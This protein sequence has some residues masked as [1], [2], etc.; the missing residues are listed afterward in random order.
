MQST[1]AGVRYEG[2]EDRIFRE[3]TRNHAILLPMTAAADRLKHLSVEEYYRLDESSDSRFD[4]YNGEVFE[5]SGGTSRHSAIGADLLIAL[6]NQLKGKPCQ[7]FTADQRIRAKT[8][9]YR[10]HPDLSII[11][12]GIEYEDDASSNRHTATNPTVLFEI[13]SPSTEGSTRGNKWLNAQ[14][15]ESLRVFVLLSQDEPIVEI[16]ERRDDSDEWIY[17]TVRGLD[18][19]LNIGTIEV[20]ISMREIYERAL[21]MPE[22]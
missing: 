13:L 19:T 12:G 10:F 7:P 21:A 1:G 17:R 6:G 16:Y 3:S 2:P 8:S 18:A 14:F 11:C 22:R 5:N 9:S 15:I 4:Y 20:A